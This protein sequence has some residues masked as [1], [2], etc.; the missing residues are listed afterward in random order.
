M[1]KFFG[2]LLLL[3]ALVGTY[4]LYTQGKPEIIDTQIKEVGETSESISI[5]SEEIREE[6][7]T[8]SRPVI[9]GEGLLAQTAREYVANTLKEFKAQAD[10]DVP[11]MREDF[12]EES[13]AAS[14]SIEIIA[15][16]IESAKTGSVIISVYVYTGGAHGSS[17]YKTFT[18][19]K[20]NGE[21][22]SLAD[23]IKQDSW[24]AFTALVKE[25][26]N[27]WQPAGSEAPVVFEDDVASLTFDSLV[28]WA[29]DNKN[30][31]LYWSQYEVGPGVLGA[32]SFPLSL[33]ELDA[34]L[35]Q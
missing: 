34:F 19:S 13:P 23:M 6:N 24:E 18:A 3:V 8:G 32:F 17:S 29:L 26:L 1:K 4:Y 15:S 16:Q 31:I 30:L 28:N 12:G 20:S 10:V 11:Q 33:Q 22:L 14:Y 7:F 25:K 21:I 5:T 35:L 2:T 27:A 9:A